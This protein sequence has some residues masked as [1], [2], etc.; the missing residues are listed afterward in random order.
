[1]IDGKEVLAGNKKLMDKYNIKVDS[2]ATGSVVYIAINRNYEGMI[3]I[4]DEIKVDS[5]GAI[6][7]LKSLGISKIA[8]LT[9]DNDSTAKEVATSLELDDF[10]S[11]LLPHEKVKKLEILHRQLPKKQKLIFVGDGINDA[12]VL[13]RADIG[14]AMGGGRLRC[15]YRSFRYCSYDR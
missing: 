6:R 1:M 4:S 13:A 15:C 12:P 7:E 9:G 5:M 8:M 3:I 10:Y 14:I 11:Q 2:N